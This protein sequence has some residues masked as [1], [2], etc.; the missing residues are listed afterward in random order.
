MLE[1][2]NT[3]CVM[4]ASDTDDKFVCPACNV[5]LRLPM[6]VSASLRLPHQYFLKDKQYVVTGF[7]DQCYTKRLVPLAIVTLTLK[8]LNTPAT[9]TTVLE[10]IMRDEFMNSPYNVS[11]VFY[12]LGL[13]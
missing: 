12:L 2:Q 3:G 10:G 4:G 11:M 6:N 13:G 5:R 9:F 1:G 8:S 7:S